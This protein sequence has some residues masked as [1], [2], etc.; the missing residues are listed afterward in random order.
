M[1]LYYMNVTIHVLAALLWLGGMFFFATVGAPALRQVEPPRLRALLF[2]RLGVR[3]RWVGW[4]AIATLLVTGTFN[5][6]FRGVLSWSV[7][8]DAA[9]WATPFGHALAWKLGAVA[10]M[11]VVSAL[12]DFVFGPRASV[13]D[14]EGEAAR[15]LRRRAAFLARANAALGLIVVLA[16]VRLARGG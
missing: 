1:S 12:H 11:L 6:W 14:P 9:F 13:E 2:H 3:F 5:L 8:G 15:R 16:A 10:A 7:L 4:G